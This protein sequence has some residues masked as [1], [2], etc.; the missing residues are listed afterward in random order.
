MDENLMVQMNVKKGLP[1]FI[2]TA[3]REMAL[4]LNFGLLRLCKSG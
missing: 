3:G 1:G 2:G 4:F